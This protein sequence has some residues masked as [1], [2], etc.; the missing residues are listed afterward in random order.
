MNQD[1]YLSMS[2]AAEDSGI[3]EAKCLIEYDR[4]LWAIENGYHAQLLKMSPEDCT[5]KHHV[6]Y[7]TNSKEKRKKEESD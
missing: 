3:Y 2:K 6:I 4:A 1:E 5:P 7:L